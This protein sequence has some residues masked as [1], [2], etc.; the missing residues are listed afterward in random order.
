M[1]EH[2]DQAVKGVFHYLRENRFSK[3][4]KKNF[5]WATRK[6]RHFLSES[7]LD[8]SQEIAAQW[9]FALEQQVSRK[10]FL[11]CRRALALL[12]QVFTYGYVKD[13]HFSY[14]I[15]R[16]RFRIPV[17]FKGSFEAYL[18]RRKEECC[19]RSTIQMD[20]CACSRFLLFLENNGVTTFTQLTP[21]LAKA[22][23]LQEVHR[24]IEGKNAY[25]RRVKGFI[26]FLASTGEVQDTLESVLPV[27][28][29]SRVAIVKTLSDEQISAID[30]YRTDAY[31]PSELRNS[32]MAMLALRLGLRS[33]DICNL[34]LANIRWDSATLAITQQKTGRPLTLPF[35][36]VVGNALSRYLLE[37]R[38]KCNSPYVF[39][40]LKRPY[41][42]LGSTKSCHRASVLILGVKQSETDCRGLHIARKTYAS[43]LLKANIPVSLIAQV[44][45][46][47]NETNVDKYLATD[48]QRMRTCAISLSGIQPPEVLQ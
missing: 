44:L 34:R 9:L 11:F 30:T 27:E 43:E 23:S 41:Q 17:H 32:A 28:K 33:V 8:Y 47:A 22:Y 21:E 29:A 14:G 37:G 10:K 1:Y 16:T 36:A 24:T 26:R 48:I 25:I 15:T 5:G 35:P 46:H 38:P 20:R 42:H 3:T 19:A 45:G 39:I 40:T 12:D 13:T 6:F 4:P 31:S 18:Q 7:K 2:Y